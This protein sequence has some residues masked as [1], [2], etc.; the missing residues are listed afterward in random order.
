MFSED[1]DGSAVPIP[2][3]LPAGAAIYVMRGGTIALS[4]LW[5]QGG[6]A[7]NFRL[8]C[9]AA[10]LD[11]LISG[12]QEASKAAHRRRVLGKTMPF[13][14]WENLPTTEVVALAGDAEPAASAER[15]LRLVKGEGEGA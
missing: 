2:A 11:R 15:V 8:V 6:R 7:R 3:D 12:M 10:M 5:R 9:S 13:L 4:F 14:H 1:G